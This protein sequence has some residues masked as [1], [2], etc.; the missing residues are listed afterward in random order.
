MQ[1]VNKIIH[2]PT[3]L[4]IMASLMTLGS[5]EQ[6]NFVYLRKILNVTDGNLG[7]HL[8]K[9]EEAGYI[10]IKKTFISR[11]PRSFISLTNKGRSKYEDY[12]ASLKSIIHTDIVGNS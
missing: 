4:S 7:A 11:K 9:L 2:Q 10:K 8:T 5:S 1:S 6:V 3:R 12:V